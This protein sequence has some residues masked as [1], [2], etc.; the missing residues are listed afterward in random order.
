MTEEAARVLP[1]IH[2]V[3]QPK[4]ANRATL[5]RWFHALGYPTKEIAA[6]LQVRY[7][8][9]RNVIVTTPKRA[10]R[11]DMPPLELE[12]WDLADDIQAIMDAELDR[13]LA[14]GRADRLSG[15]YSEDE[16][17]EDLRA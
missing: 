4:V 16:I 7:Q 8:Q 17:D 13:S 14:A 9:V 1:P 15:S 5:I 2:R 6:Q 12:T 3:K 10:A 11:E